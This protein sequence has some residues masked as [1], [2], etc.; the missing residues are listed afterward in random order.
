MSS[1]KVEF[2]PYAFS[3]NLLSLDR[4]MEGGVTNEVG[5]LVPDY[6]R[7]YTWQ[8]KDV[9]RLF[10][11]ILSSLSARTKR[12]SSHFL[13]ATVWNK[14]NRDTHEP[15]FTIDSYDIVDGQQRLT[16]CLLLTMCLIQE[17]KNSQKELAAASQVPHE[18][19][20]WLTAQNNQVEGEARTMI[21]GDLRRS[22]LPFPRIINEDDV[23][24][25][26]NLGAEYKLPLAKLIMAFG[27]ALDDD[28]LP[29]DF[30]AIQISED[31]EDVFLRL[32]DNM[33]FFTGYLQQI[34][35][36]K[37][38]KAFNI[39]FIQ[40]QE[41][42]NSHLRNL[43]TS[44][45]P[46]S[47]F[48]RAINTNEKF[49]THIRLIH[50]FWH[51]LK[52]TCVSVITC[53]DEDAAFSIF[54]SLNTTGVPLTA[55][56]TLK[57]YVMRDY[58]DSR[59]SFKDSPA[60]ESFRYVEK[61]IRDAGNDANKQ[62]DVSKEFAI[63]ASLLGG[64]ANIINNNLSLQRS[65]LREIHQNCMQNGDIDLSSTVLKKLAEFRS[66]LCYVDG[67]RNYSAQPTLSNKEED[68][69][70]LISIFLANSG[71]RLYRP[72][73]TR[74]FWNTS[75]VKYFHTACKALAA[76]Y[77]LRRAT[78]NTTDR[79]DDIFRSTMVGTDTYKGLELKYKAPESLEEADIV[80]LKNHL[81]SNLKSSGLDFT[82]S[83]KNEWVEHVKN[84]AHF[85]GAKSL[86]RFMLF[87]A[88]D[89]A[90]IDS[91]D[92]TL[93]QRED[94]SPDSSTEF[95]SF[96]MW[97]R[98]LY[99][100]LEHIAPQNEQS[101][102]W[103]GIYDE[104]NLKNTIG[105]F[106]LLPKGQ[107]SA[108]KDSEWPIKKL[109]LQVLLCDSITARKTLV[110][111]AEAAG[112]MLPPSIKSAVLSSG[113]LMKSHMLS[114]LENVNEWDAS[115]IQKRSRRLCELVWDKMEAWLN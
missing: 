86:L 3:S 113:S 48:D 96:S 26:T 100:T 59:S 6:Q 33:C 19:D 4:I 37:F 73:L 87:V 36:E 32:T 49:E 109:F 53:E 30:D 114:G 39:P 85:N 69:A 80:D 8:E 16:T 55:I 38:F 47:E 13:G 93:I 82:L 50:F 35:D 5:L 90:K 18:L 46:E 72:I 98:D 74:F 76:F 22:E 81:K 111:S 78:S 88:H 14:R 9:E 17:I 83:S 115:F 107:N 91:N 106:V 27:K 11:D 34:S 64:N 89:G 23:R 71:T 56:Q 54:D 20:N 7:N 44:H 51:F 101:S 62:S 61:I 68:E 31:N 15:E 105:N 95:L 63:H 65:V 40:K 108:L 10:I 60:E 29:L 97:D 94:A 52:A 99:E 2:N 79:I 67:I 112:T 42:K 21:V 75:E 102:G 104:P 92:N 28:N 45:P 12:P 58:R 77:V 103:S 84:M 43:F 25:R 66:E 1:N 24:G 41:L 57:P 110:A 70:K